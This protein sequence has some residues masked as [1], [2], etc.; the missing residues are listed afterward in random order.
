MFRNLVGCCMALLLL[1]AGCSSPPK[2]PDLGGIYNHL[3]QHEDPYRNPIIL[4]PGLLGSKLV[5]PDS[6]MIVWGA[7]GTGTLNPNKPEGAR[8]FG[9]PMQPGKNLHELKDGV[10]PVGTLDRVV[11]N[12]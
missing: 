12:F 6:E 4:I 2:T 8:L 7:F 1:L 3:A 9:L 5:D 11:V 10:K